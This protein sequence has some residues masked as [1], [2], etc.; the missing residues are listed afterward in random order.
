MD[1]AHII[2]QTNIKR[3]LNALAAF[4]M[5][6]MYI[7]GTSGQQLHQFIHAHDSLV[8]HSEEAEKDNCH[9]SIYH[10]DRQTG[11]DHPAHIVLGDTCAL[12]DVFVYRD[13]TILSVV[14][15]ISKTISLTILSASSATPVRIHYVFLSTRA[16]PAS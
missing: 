9:R 2:K 1:L 3:G 4:S 5:L 6:V 14:P 10:H 12:C 7:A 15:F 8:S 11:C 13:H 16:P